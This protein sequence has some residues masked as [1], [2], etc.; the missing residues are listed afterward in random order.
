MTNRKPLSGG[1][2]KIIMETKKYFFTP[3]LEEKFKEYRNLKTQKDKDAFLEKEKNDLEKKPLKEREL[4]YD[5]VQKGVSAIGEHVE[6]LIEK[7]E[8]GEVA[9]IISM[10]YIA[11]KYFGRTRH[12]LYHRLNGNI[13]NGKTVRFTS[14]ERL[15]LKQ[16]LQDVER[17]LHNTS[18]KIS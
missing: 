7:V 16:A 18:F 15:K 10:S 1:A 12:W 5:A 17:I 4:Y 13:V 9:N 14:E 11:K 2:K 3:V 8:L 6:E